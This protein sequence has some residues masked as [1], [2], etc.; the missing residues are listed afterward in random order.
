MR[1]SQ[2]IYLSLLCYMPLLRVKGDA[3]ADLASAEQAFFTWHEQQAPEYSTDAGSKA[4]NDR[5]ADLSM[6]A[7]DADY[8][9][10]EGFINRTQAIDRS[11]L[12]RQQGYSYDIFLDTLTTFASNYQW[13]QFGA[14]NPVN[15]MESFYLDLDYI[16]DIAPFDTKGDYENYIARLE[17]RPKQIN[18]IMD[19]MH[20]AIR[21]GTTYNLVSVLK[22]P[23]QIAEVIN[24][25]PVQSTL[26]KPFN[27]T[28]DKLTLGQT[29]KDDM[30]ARGLQGLRGVWTAL[31]RLKTFISD[32]YSY[33]TRGTYGVGGLPSGGS[34]Y[35]AC[36]KWHLS[37]DTSP[38]QVHQLGMREVDRITH[39]MQ[40]VMSRQAFQGTVAEYYTKL[41][42]DPQF[43]RSSADEILKDFRNLIFNRIYPKLPQLFKDIPDN[44][45]VVK[46]LP[47]DGPYGM[48]SSGSDDGSRPGTFYVNLRRPNETSTFTMVSLTLHETV[49]GHHLQYV[50][51]AAAK[52]PSFQRHIDYN[53]YYAVP[54][55]FPFYTAYTEG[56]ALYS[57]FLGEELGVYQDDYELMGRYGDEIFRACR[58]VVDTG[59]HYLGWTRQKAIEYISARTPMPQ[60]EVE[61]EVD[62]YLT[63][64]GQACAYKIGEL[65]IK[66]LRQRAS[67]ALGDKF[68]IR[69]FHSLLLNN[70]PVPLKVMETI[71]DDFISDQ[72]GNAH[73]GGPIVG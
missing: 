28:L 53:K 2:I 45:V 9:A 55:H 54:Y 70:G 71:V 50:Y 16:I 32:D 7:F 48:Y 59:M 12:S 42:A 27:E 10:V 67:S 36:L 47:Y 31:N 65:K 15:F 3:S 69:D 38:P 30:R 57:E 60:A 51:Q 11:Q 56:W 34:F 21:L 6:G 52:L 40:K 20:E 62:R 13:R 46:P 61:I 17:A 4:F 14:L 26:F 25:P 23:G 35:R 8:F 41:K 33:H 64:P 22:V 72:G 19:R 18:Q 49:P 24:T 68:D 5:L 73:S 58:L 43:H 66:E 44:K 29:D 63:W 39:N 1:A 37:L